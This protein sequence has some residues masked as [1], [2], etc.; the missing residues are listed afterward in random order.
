FCLI[1]EKLT[2]YP[3]QDVTLRCD[4]PANIS[5]A[6]VK[7][8]RKD[9]GNQHVLLYKGSLVKEGQHPSFKDRVT[10]QKGR[11]EDGE[12]SLILQNVKE[13]VNGTYECAVEQKNPSKWYLAICIFEVDVGSGGESVCVRA[14][15]WFLG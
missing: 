6:A 1:S 4:A 13:N 2:V 10:L 15:N 9:L 12:V 11:L 5:I 7:W 3:G 8:T 14:S